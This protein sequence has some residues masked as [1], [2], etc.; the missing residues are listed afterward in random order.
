MWG[1]CAACP[2]RPSDSAEAR[3]AEKHQGGSRRAFEPRARLPVPN[4][5]WGAKGR[6]L[7]GDARGGTDAHWSGPSGA[8][9]EQPYHW[10]SSRGRGRG[11]WPARGARG[12]RDGAGRH[13]G[14]SVGARDAAA[15]AAATSAG[16]GAIGR[17]I[18]LPR[19]PRRDSARPCRGRHAWR[20]VNGGGRRA[21]R[22]RAAGRGCGRALPPS[23]PPSWSRSRTR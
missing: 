13:S 5:G 1:A 7:G 19:A 8:W 21:E 12:G 15:A 23:A 20:S 22:R 10:F 16:A 11:A 18:R 3:E 6:V 4:L 2:A 14:G 17:A 9:H